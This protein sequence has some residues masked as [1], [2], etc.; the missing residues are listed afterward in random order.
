MTARRI[1]LPCV[2]LATACTGTPGRTSDTTAYFP[3]TFVAAGAR[4]ADSDSPC[5]GTM[6]GNATPILVTGAGVGLRIPP[7][8]NEEWLPH[9]RG[10]A[11]EDHRAWKNAGGG[12]EYRVVSVAELRQSQVVD[13]VQR[14]AVDVRSCDA[15]VDGRRIHVLSFHW[16][17]TFINDKPA[18]EVRVWIPAGEARMVRLSALGQLGMR[19]TMLALLRGLRIGLPPSHE[20]NFPHEREPTRAALPPDSVPVGDSIAYRGHY[21]FVNTT[22]GTDTAFRI[23]MYSTQAADVVHLE[24]IR[25]DGS[26]AEVA[27]RLLLPPAIR[28]DDFAVYNVCKIAGVA[29]PEVFGFYPRVRRDSIAPQPRLAWRAVRGTP[30]FEP[31]STAN[32]TC[33]P[34][35]DG[36]D[37]GDDGTSAPPPLVG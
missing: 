31:V 12:I 20:D 23:A 2:L 14:G 22:G 15:N 1:L 28:V 10:V 25:P 29:D 32:L 13:S 19:D 21:G 26:G 16:P 36:G 34:E 3:P 17:N 24:R 11:A 37:D 35:D 4:R 9:E 18:D 6:P 33:E 7:S 30:H 27:A 5:L 8:F